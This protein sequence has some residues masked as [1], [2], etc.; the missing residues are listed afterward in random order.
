MSD[1]FSRGV[2]ID[3]R[4]HHAGAIPLQLVQHVVQRT[5][6]FINHLLT[7]A[8]TTREPNVIEGFQVLD[9][10]SSSQNRPSSLHDAEKTFNVFSHFLNRLRELSLPRRRIVIWRLGHSPFMETTYLERQYVTQSNH[11]Q[12]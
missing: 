10:N 11:I 2:L 7:P 5:L 4:R 12:N 9:S 6:S 8:H 3:L 1:L